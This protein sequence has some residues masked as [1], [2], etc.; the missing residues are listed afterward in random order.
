MLINFLKILI[1][2]ENINYYAILASNKLAIEKGKYDLFEGSEWDSGA[3]F[4]NRNYTS[5]RWNELAKSV[6]DNGLRN[7]YLLAIAP[8]SSTSIIAGT[9]AGVDPIMKK[10][11]YEE[12]KGEMIPR[13]APELTHENSAFY[14]P[15]HE[16]DQLWS[17]RAAG[18]RQRHVD[19][20]QSVNLYITHDYSMRQ[21][22]ELYI[23]AWENGVKT[24]Y[25]VRSKSLEVEECEGCAN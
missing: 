1:T 2:F 6:H 21:I 18:V 15:A 17:V 5:E 20:A 19:Q 3:Y 16:V 7:G 11:F 12:K 8:T 14:K 13:V 25:Y 10:F 4:I 22:L 24:I 23:K 9:T